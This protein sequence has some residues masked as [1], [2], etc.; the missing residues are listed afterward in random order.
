MS[1]NIVVTLLGV[2]AALLI[3]LALVSRYPMKTRSHWVECPEKDKPLLVKF[4]RGEFGFGNFYVTDVA[5]CSF[6][7]GGEVTCNKECIKRFPVL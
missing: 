2:A 5:A 6:F 4:V 7:N 3:L 1:M